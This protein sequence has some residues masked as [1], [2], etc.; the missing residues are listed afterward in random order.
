MDVKI[1]QMIM[2][3]LIQ[4]GYAKRKIDYQEFLKLYEPYKTEMQESDFANII[5]IKYGNYMNM[6]RKGKN[7]KRIKG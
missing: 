3:K 7:K 4:Q 2:D 5:G 6:R 1:E